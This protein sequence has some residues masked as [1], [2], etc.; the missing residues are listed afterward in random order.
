M[1]VMRARGG[2]LGEPPWR[3]AVAPQLE[4]RPVQLVPGL[5]L[6]QSL[7]GKRE[8]HLHAFLVDV[9]SNCT[10]TLQG[11]E[12]LALW[13]LD[14]SLRRVAGP[15]ML[16]QQVLQPAAYWAHVGTLGPAR[17]SSG[18]YRLRLHCVAL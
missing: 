2:D 14:G 17:L 13:L 16:L 5:H 3:A 11:P 7:L 12:H 18:K 1:I 4:H 6:E 10:L 8:H 9:P 15:G